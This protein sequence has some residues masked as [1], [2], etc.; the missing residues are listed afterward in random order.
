MNITSVN[1]KI[2]KDEMPVV[3]YCSIVIDDSF[4]VRKI[5]I[6]SKNDGFIVSMPSMKN[7]LGQYTDICHPINQHARKQ[8]ETAILNAYKGQL[9]SEIV[10]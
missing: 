2:T 9:Q 7:K 3:A 4:S 10:E 5:R 6:I 1:I 8:I